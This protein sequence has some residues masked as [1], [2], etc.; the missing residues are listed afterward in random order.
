MRSVNPAGADRSR[1]STASCFRDTRRGEPRDKGAKRLT[2]VC[3]RAK[4]NSLSAMLEHATMVTVTGTDK[5]DKAW[6]IEYSLVL[7]DWIVLGG[8]Q[9]SGAADTID[10]KGG[11]DTIFGWGGDDWLYGG[12]GKD[13][14]AGGKG[15]DHIFG[16]D[17]DDHDLGGGDGDDYIDGGSG[18]NVFYG[19]AGNDSLISLNGTEGN[20]LHGG[21]GNDTYIIDS[22]NDRVA[23]YDGEGYDRVL[24]RGFEFRPNLEILYDPNQT[25]KDP[26]VLFTSE[27]EEIVYDGPSKTSVVV[28]GTSTNNIIRT[29]DGSDTI[30]SHGGNDVV[31]A[32]GGQD[33]VNGG[34]G[35]DKLYGGDGQDELSGDRDDDVLDGG[36]GADR[37][38][39]GIGND[40]YVVDNADD[41]VLGEVVGGGFDVIES[42]VLSTMALKDVWANTGSDLR[43]VEG[44]AYTGSAAAV[45]TGNSLGNQL[46]A[47]WAAGATLK[48]GAG[49]DT[50]YGSGKADVLEGGDDDDTL[51]GG[52]GH[53]HLEGG[54][55]IDTYFGGTGNDTYVVDA[56]SEKVVEQAGEGYDTVL[57]WVD[58]VLSSN[59]ERADL[60]SDMGGSL[61]GNDLANTLTGSKV[62]GN[63][64]NGGGGKDKLTGGNASDTLIGGTGQDSMYGFLGDDTF[65]VDSAD[66]IVHEWLD[67]GED[68]IVTS[69]NYSLNDLIYGYVEELVAE[70]L[71]KSFVLSGNQLDNTIR[72]AGKDDTLSGKGG[73]DR[74]FGYAGADTLSG[75][76]GDDRLYGGLGND[77]LFG[78]EDDDTHYGGGGAD[79]YFFK[80]G[81]GADTIADFEDGL[82]KVAVTGGKL[83]DLV[84]GE[85]ADGVT[86]S[87]SGL[88][89][90]VLLAGINPGAVT[91]AD[92]VF[93]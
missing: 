29:K 3:V 65:H 68:K 58:Y 54:F 71:D 43:Y 21:K 83:S 27:I 84:L 30:Y 9:G 59:V 47:F 51:Y 79:T 53:D 80:S 86:I 36:T 73:Q 17:G 13:R 69:V 88:D 91:A 78:G 33:T 75:G 41:L 25:S 20:A 34:N 2:G 38:F 87:F 62:G 31:H 11:D 77:K 23:E 10:G 5:N 28:E 81:D 85:T 35:N 48:G 49:D 24:F 39:G 12:S 74:L 26:D 42:A 1:K 64:L 52:G 19:G 57:A 8:L 40:R 6:L 72:A 14:I 50:L 18:Y 37:L 66:D 7:Q 76:V 61:I 92:F 22:A 93:A 55:G 45:L 4:G 63:T 90:S 15:N 60:L 70:N 44:L 89:F 67:S 82:D 46:S 16:G 56:S 32:G